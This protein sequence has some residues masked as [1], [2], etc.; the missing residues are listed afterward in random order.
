[1][2]REVG[3]REKLAE[4]EDLRVVGGGLGGQF[5]RPGDIAVPNGLEVDTGF[6]DLLDASRQE[7][8]IA[9]GFCEGDANAPGPVPRV[10]LSCHGVW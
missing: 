2:K 8:R 9:A 6:G 1:V 3:C 4:P 5:Q 7:P 10:P